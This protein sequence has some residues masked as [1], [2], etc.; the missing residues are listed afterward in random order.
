MIRVHVCAGE[1]VEGWK[2]SSCE[3]NGRVVVKRI[4]PLTEWSVWDRV[5]HEGAR[6][7]R[8]QQEAGC[9]GLRVPSL[10]VPEV[11]RIREMTAVL[12]IASTANTTQQWTRE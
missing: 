5:G 2:V 1:D 11:R 9:L 6:K 12:R 4:G 3:G 10:R 7:R 8:E